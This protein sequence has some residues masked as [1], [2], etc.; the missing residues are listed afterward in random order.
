VTDHDHVTGKVR[1]LLC[2][3]CNQALGLI[4]DSIETAKSF[5]SYLQKFNVETP[6]PTT[7]PPL[8]TPVLQQP[9]FPRTYKCE[10]PS[11]PM[12][13]ES[14]VDEAQELLSRVT[15]NAPDLKSLYADKLKPEPKNP[16][17]PIADIAYLQELEQQ[18]KNPIAP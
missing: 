1:G 4:K 6:P 12:M 10:G 16:G 3:N 9:M 8:E 2:P 17:L 11:L 15:V 18:R 7:I 14:N 13:L 5:V